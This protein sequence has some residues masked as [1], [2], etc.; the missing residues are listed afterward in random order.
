MFRNGA[1]RPFQWVCR[2]SAEDQERAFGQD[3]PGCA[4][5]RRLLRTSFPQGQVPLK[6]GE[7]YLHFRAV[8]EIYQGRKS[9]EVHCFPH[10]Q[11][12]F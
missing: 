11:F 7:R 5:E 9:E 6:Q 12:K 4:A 3:L 10:F 1:G 2:F 8:S